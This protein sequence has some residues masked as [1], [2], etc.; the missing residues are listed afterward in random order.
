[1]LSTD[2]VSPKREHDRVLVSIQLAHVELVSLD[3]HTLCIFW[4]TF[5]V[6]NWIASD[7]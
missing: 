3:V 2:E 5:V 6:I 7:L 1:M 4:V